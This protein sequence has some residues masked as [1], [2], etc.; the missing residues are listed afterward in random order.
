MEEKLCLQTLTKT[1]S[2]GVYSLT[3]LKKISFALS[4]LKNVLGKEAKKVERKD[5]FVFLINMIHF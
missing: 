3:I 4:L 5:G 1:A 2:E